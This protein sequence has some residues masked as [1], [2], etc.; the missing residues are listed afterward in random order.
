VQENLK[1]MVVGSLIKLVKE[2]EQLQVSMVN[3]YLF[4]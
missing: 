4:L 2:L 1:N 3:N